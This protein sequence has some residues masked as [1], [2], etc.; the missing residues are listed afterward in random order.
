MRKSYW[1]EE[2]LVIR[3]VAVAVAVEVGLLVL[4]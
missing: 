2:Q 1:L 4:A 3:V